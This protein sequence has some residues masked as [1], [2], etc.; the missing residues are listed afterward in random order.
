MLIAMYLHVTQHS[1]PTL[2]ATS[3][4]GWVGPLVLV[5]AAAALTWVGFAARDRR[6]TRGRTA[7]RR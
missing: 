5:G 1:A 7:R 4:P 2:G 6:F 3:T